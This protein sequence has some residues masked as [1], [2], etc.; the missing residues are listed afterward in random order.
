MAPAFEMRLPDWK[1]NQL[2]FYDSAF[3]MSVRPDLADGTLENK[4]KVDEKGVRG[5]FLKF[6]VTILKNYRQYV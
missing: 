2:P 4:D 5:S 3:E 6:M 1:R